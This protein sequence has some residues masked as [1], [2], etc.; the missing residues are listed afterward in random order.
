MNL[1][2]RDGSPFWWYTFTIGG[3]VVRKSTGRLLKD[4]KA[5]QEVLVSE[6]T[7]A[8]DIEQF[9]A[10][11][12]ITIREAMEATVGSV[13]GKT[14][15]SYQTSMDSLLGEG[16]YA[17]KGR[18][19]LD[20]SASM[21]SLKQEQLTRHREARRKETTRRGKLL[22]VNSINIEIRFML[23]VYNY[24]KKDLGKAVTPDLTFTQLKKFEKRRY[25]HDNE[26]Q[27]IADELLGKGG[28]Y[29]KAWDLYILLCDTGISLME[30]VMLRWKQVDLKRMVITIVRDKTDIPCLVPISNRVAEMLE[31]KRNQP[32]PFEGMSR[33]IRILRTTIST[34]CNTDELEVRK[35][36]SCTI[37]SLRDTFATRRVKD[38]MT[39]AEVAKMIGHTNTTMTK[40]Y[41]HEETAYVTERARELM[42]RRSHG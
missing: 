24:T 9:G 16:W 39:L 31:R 1:Y 40:K 29:Q 5:A 3:Q 13:Q 27:L 21:S 23:R 17:G 7:R 18:W 41:E 26:E 22:A 36:G 6:Y 35:M 32:T 25:V 4:R 34:V 28:S 15:Q 30:G 12:E 8:K 11:D 19:K 10:K 38:G 37:H 14:Q 42:N 20:G 2:K 33:A